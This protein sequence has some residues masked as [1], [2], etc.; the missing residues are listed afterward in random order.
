MMRYMRAAV[1]AAIFSLSSIAVGLTQEDCIKCVQFRTY[2]CM[3]NR[4]QCYRDCDRFVTGNKEA[5]RGRCRDREQ[6]CGE[7][8][9]LKCGTCKPGKF[10]TPPPARIQ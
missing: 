9:T 5:C 4:L 10:A 2:A 3:Q 8:T 6:D 1:L 7:L